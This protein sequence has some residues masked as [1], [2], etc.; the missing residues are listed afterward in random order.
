MLTRRT[1]VAGALALL[2]G[3]AA[4]QKIPL[5]DISAYLNGLTTARGSFTQRTSDGAVSTGTVYIKRP[6]RVRFEYNPPDR[7]MVIAGGGSLAVFDPRSD[8]PARYALQ[9][10][11]LSIILARNVDLGRA[12]MVTGHVSDGDTTIVRAQDPDNPEYGYIDLMFSPNPVEL[13]QWV[14]TDGNGAQ[15]T[16]VLGDLEKG[17][18]VPNRLFN[19][20]AE[21]RDWGQ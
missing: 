8:E 11:P 15:T 14:I 5:N 6:G 3:P 9:F 10:T 2:A 4:A 13:R 21:T 1:L 12:D 16:I 20:L 7:A 18:Q 17:V 19:I